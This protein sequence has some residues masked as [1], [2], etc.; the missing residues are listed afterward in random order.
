MAY[1]TLDELIDRYGEG[2]LVQLTDRGEE[3]SGEVNAATVARAIAD[4][5]AII[6]GYLKN[7]Y[8]LPLSDTP[9]LLAD[10]AKTVAFYKLHTAVAPDKARRDY[11]DAMRLLDKIA[12][13]SIRLDVAGA[14]PAASGSSGVRTNDR[15][16]ELTPD[17]MKGFV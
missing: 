14:E 6:D 1:C 3:A 12:S 13:G 10:I 5:D 7:R 2:E 4:T 8:L 16:R 11:E 9:P 17:N 15:E